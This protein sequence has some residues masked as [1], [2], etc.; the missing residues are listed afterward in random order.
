MDQ[1]HSGVKLCVC[2]CVCVLCVCVLCVCVVVVVVRV[3]HMLQTARDLHEATRDRH[4][5]DNPGVVFQ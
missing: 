1:H 3:A 4:R 2:V 5:H